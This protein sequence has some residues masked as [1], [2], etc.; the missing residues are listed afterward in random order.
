M[1]DLIG[2]NKQLNYSLI[3]HVNTYTAE[4]TW[5][6][7]RCPFQGRQRE[8]TC[9]SVP[10]IPCP[11]LI[12]WLNATLGYFLYLVNHYCAMGC[13]WD[14]GQIFYSLQVRCTEYFLIGCVL[15]IFGYRVEDRDHTAYAS[16]H[17]PMH[18][19]HG[20]TNHKISVCFLC[21]HLWVPWHIE[22][23]I[24]YTILHLNNV[25]S[26][27]G[28]PAPDLVIRVISS[29]RAFHDTSK[30][31]SFKAVSLVKCS[32]EPTQSEREIEVQI[33]EDVFRQS[34]WSMVFPSALPT[35]HVG[36]ERFSELFYMK[37][38]PENYDL[39]QADTFQ[40]FL[41]QPESCDKWSVA[42]VSELPLLPIK[43]VQDH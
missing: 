40:K 18:Q 35:F 39:F 7:K 14:C 28:G 34:F 2:A 32:G 23:C 13:G 42:I 24:F 6:T 36:T 5:L 10:A 20:D 33:S 30:S 16:L 9:Q 37:N 15:D 43:C 27:D 29:F 17:D 21:F 3:S 31:K 26:W 8:Q 25:S 19:C 1:G 38:K 12:P 41:C 4:D 22:L 11:V